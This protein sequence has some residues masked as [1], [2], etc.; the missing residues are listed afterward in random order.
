MGVM[1]LERPLTSNQVDDLTDALVN[2]MKYSATE[3]LYPSLEGAKR[4][5]GVIAEWLYPLYNASN[6]SSELSA[7]LMYTQQETLFEEIGELM[8]G[9]ALVEMKHYSKLSDLICQ[10]GG[11]IDQRYNNGSVETGKTPREALET[12]LMSEGKTIEAYEKFLEKIGDI[13][14]T[15]TIRIT[16]QLISK[17]IADEEIHR[18]LLQDALSKFTIQEL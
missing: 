14:E 6:D 3:V 1:K 5:D 12:A 17:I 10:L 18:S 15:K 9:I 11:K 7:I 4:D 13:K 2:V 16:R 8:L